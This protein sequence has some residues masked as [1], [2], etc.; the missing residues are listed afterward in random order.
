MLD[1]K[2]NDNANF[3]SPGSSGS[4]E[5]YEYDD[6]TLT[7]MNNRETRREITETGVFYHSS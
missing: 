2:H 6:Q 1:Q 3:K 4:I 5:Y 7:P